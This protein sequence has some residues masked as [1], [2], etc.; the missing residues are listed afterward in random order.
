MIQVIQVR[1]NRFY[2]EISPRFSL[3]HVLGQLPP[4]AC[5][6]TPRKAAV[7]GRWSHCRCAERPEELNCYVVFG[8]VADGQMVTLIE[9]SGAAW[10]PPQVGPGRRLI[11]LPDGMYTIIPGV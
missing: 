2:F 8:A 1:I 10:Q 11:T 5:M 3:Q 4:R 9:S 7:D 6:Q